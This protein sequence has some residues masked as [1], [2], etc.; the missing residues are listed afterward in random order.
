MIHAFITVSDHILEDVVALRAEKVNAVMGEP[1]PVTADLVAAG[2][3][4]EDSHIGDLE[5]VVPN[6]DIPGAFQK[7]MVIAAVLDAVVVD[8]HMSEVLKKDSIILG[9]TDL[10][11][12]DDDLMKF[13]PIHEG[14]SAVCGMGDFQ[15]LQDDITLQPAEAQGAHSALEFSV[16]YCKICDSVPLDEV[17]PAS[18]VSVPDRVTLQINPHIIRLDSQGRRPRKMVV[19]IQYVEPR[20]GDTRRKMQ[21]GDGRGRSDVNRKGGGRK[22]KRGCEGDESVR[23]AHELPHG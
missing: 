11:A 19:S 20:A 12:G 8:P 7:D 4:D 14:D 17:F 16:P 9:V 23:P 21:H 10:I 15:V 3:V 1:D 6:V 18:G 2:S 22:P 5:I 13:G